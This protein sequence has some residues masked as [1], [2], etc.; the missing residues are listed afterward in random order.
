M[1]LR[2]LVRFQ[3]LMRSLFKTPYPGTDAEGERKWPN[4]LSNYAAIRICLGDTMFNVPQ[5]IKEAQ[6]AVTIRN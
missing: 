5:R 3:K 2:K 6:V 1:A 4:A